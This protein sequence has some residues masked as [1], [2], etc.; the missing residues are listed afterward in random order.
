M[1]RLTRITEPT[2]EPLTLAQAKLHLKVDF[3]EDDD[4]IE[5]L[6]SSARDYCERYCNRAWALSNWRVEFDKLPTSNNEITLLDPSTSAISSIKY[7]DADKAEQTI[8]SL[9]YTL[10]T[11]RAAVF[12]DDSWPDFTSSVVIDYTAG[13][14]HSASP[15]EIIPKSVLAGIKLVL[16][17]LYENRA[18]QMDVRMYE[19]PAVSSLLYPYRVGIGI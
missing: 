5:S 1:K 7:I 3:D 11:S 2:T 14:D 13:A 4:L 10:D 6:I 19:N 9:T 8:S 15:P 17:D 12:I 16:T 18:G